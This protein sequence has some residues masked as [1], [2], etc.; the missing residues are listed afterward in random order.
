MTLS[1]NMCRS[2]AFVMCVLTPSLSLLSSTQV[3]VDNFVH[4]DLHPGNILV[5][6]VEEALV[7]PS[8]TVDFHD[9]ITEF[10]VYLKEP[11][12]PIKLVLLDTGITSHLEERDFNNFYQVFT[13]I[14][15]RKV[16][17]NLKL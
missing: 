16:S 10:Q 13:A 17:A 12:N 11:K 2:Y 15:M 1:H 7:Q 9:H 6:G 4:A 3:F 5:Q 14:V 8:R